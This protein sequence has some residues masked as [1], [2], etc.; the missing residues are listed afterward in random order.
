MVPPTHPGHP[1]TI[2]MVVIKQG[3]GG[4]TWPPWNCRSSF[5]GTLKC[6]LIKK[7]KVFC[8]VYLWNR[9][10]NHNFVLHGPIQYEWIMVS[11]RRNDH[12]LFTSESKVWKCVFNGH[13][14]WHRTHNGSIVPPLDANQAHFHRFSLVPPWYFSLW[15]KCEWTTEV[16][17]REMTTTKV[18]DVCAR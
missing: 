5:S 4:E 6:Q 16:S 11:L 3:F 10:Q 8:D 12:L 17:K 13:I 14:R 9:F 7:R 1:V 2:E 15:A 18:W